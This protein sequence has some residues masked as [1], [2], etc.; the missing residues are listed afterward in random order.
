MAKSPASIRK[1]FGL[2]AFTLSMTVFM[3]AKPP[4]S[5]GLPS[6]T[7]RSASKCECMS[8]VKIMETSVEEE[9]CAGKNP[10]ANTVNNKK[11]AV[12][13]NTL[14]F[15]KMRNDM[16]YIYLSLMNLML[17]YFSFISNTPSQSFAG[18]F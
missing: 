6:I 10:A 2:S 18:G 1:V 15:F 8:W 17:T 14:I 7:Q 9:D 12:I 5:E 4:R 13:F 16:L 3:R 11:T